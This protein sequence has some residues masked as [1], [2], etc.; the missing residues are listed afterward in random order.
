MF[1][2]T[3]VAAIM[4]LLFLNGCAGAEKAG[5]AEEGARDVGVYCP[6]SG[7]RLGA[8]GKVE[9]VEYRGEKYY[10]CCA[11]CKAAFEANPGR[12]L[13]ETTR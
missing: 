4:G 12:Y 7:D 9:T 13:G 6:V 11:G 1:R 8:P 5:S 10:F 3:F 2:L